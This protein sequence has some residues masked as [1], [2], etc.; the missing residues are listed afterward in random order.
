MARI[1]PFSK[2]EPW[3]SRVSRIFREGGGMLP[4]ALFAGAEILANLILHSLQFAA[5]PAVQARGIEN[6]SYFS[7]PTCR[8]PPWAFH[9]TAFARNGTGSVHN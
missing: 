3:R 4:P 5:A 1:S 9:G 2:T 7:L 8:A 6:R